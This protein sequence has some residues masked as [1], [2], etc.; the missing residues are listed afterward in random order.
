M[1]SRMCK[2]M[3]IMSECHISENISIIPKCLKCR[4]K[5][6]KSIGRRGGNGWDRNGG[7]PRA[8][9]MAC[10]EMTNEGGFR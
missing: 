10:Q 5:S 3:P 4:M 6:L 9:T 2:E 7:M 1:L 8:E